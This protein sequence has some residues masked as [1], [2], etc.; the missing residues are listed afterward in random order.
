MEQTSQESGGVTILGNVKKMSGC[1]IWLYGLVGRVGLSQSL[2]IFEIFP[3][4]IFCDAPAAKFLSQTAEVSSVDWQIQGTKGA[5]CRLSPIPFSV[6]PSLQ[7]R[8]L[9]AAGIRCWA[10]GE[11]VI[12]QATGS[13]EIIQPN[14]A[15]CWTSSKP[16]FS[17]SEDP[18]SSGKLEGEGKRGLWRGMIKSSRN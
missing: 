16:E 6:Y 1:G 18:Q 14:G 11:G 13:N 10:G 17:L 7:P 8:V 5:Q 15:A 9:S 4:Q 3:T 12:I 2:M